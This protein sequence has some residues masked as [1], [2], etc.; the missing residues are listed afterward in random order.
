MIDSLCDLKSVRSYNGELK[1]F[2]SDE[3]R[4]E[5]DLDWTLFTKDTECLI[6]HTDQ[7]AYIGDIHKI[8]DL[9]WIKYIYISSYEATTFD[10]SV[11]KSNDKYTIFNLYDPSI[12]DLSFL[13][14]FCLVNPKTKLNLSY[15]KHSQ[16]IDLLPYIYSISLTTSNIT[17][18][19]GYPLLKSIEIE[20][21]NINVNLL[22]ESTDYLK[23]N[24]EIINNFNEFIQYALKARVQMLEIKSELT[25]FYL[26]DILPLLGKIPILNL[27]INLNLSEQEQY[28]LVTTICTSD[29]IDSLYLKKNN[30]AIITSQNV[31]DHLLKLLPG[32]ISLE[33]LQLGLEY[34]YF[35]MTSKICKRNKR[36]HRRL[37]DLETL[38]YKCAMNHN[39]EIPEYLKKGR[40]SNI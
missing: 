34:K 21:N 15:Q 18:L 35:K 36:N 7:S 40:F 31:I 16:F 29:N 37:L 8:F 25:I 4:V 6:I 17:D 28:E 32:N 9:P 11:L 3:F 1:L 10:I 27:D 20:C 38:A 24:I 23:I 12:N 33:L 14:K 13:Y 19:R 30:K 5:S 39:L 2:F 26:S 22:P